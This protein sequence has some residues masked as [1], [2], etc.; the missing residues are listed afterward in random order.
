MSVAHK[1]STICTWG[2]S[3]AGTHASGKMLSFEKKTTAKQ[4]EQ[5]DENGELYS[6]VLHD[7]REEISVELL[8]T[9]SSVRPATGTTFTIVGTPSVDYIVTESADKWSAGSTKKI[10]VSAYRSVPFV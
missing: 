2:T 5:E 3:S 4:F 1:T 6:L 10:S 7:R 8:A 9:S